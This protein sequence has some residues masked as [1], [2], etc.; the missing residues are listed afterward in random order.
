MKTKKN[1]VVFTLLFISFI[2]YSQKTKKTEKIT[3]QELYTWQTLDKGKRT[4][5]NDALILEETD[6]SD[7]YFLISKKRYKGDYTISY[8]IKAI[9]KS[10]VLITLFSVSERNYSNKLSIPKNDISPEKIWQWRSGLKHYN[11]TFNNKSHGNKPFFFK[12]LSPHSRGFYQNLPKN[13]VDIGKWYDVEIGKK[14]TRLW[15]K[16]NN[17]LIFDVQDCEPLT[18][19]HLIFR[20]SGTTGDKPILAKAAIKDIVISYQ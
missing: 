12:N 14:G 3:P 19:G 17:D 9:S 15:F 10:T 20:I 18:E 11:L 2:S 16:L 6:G 8:K 1:N 4:I 13:I 5:K 7:G